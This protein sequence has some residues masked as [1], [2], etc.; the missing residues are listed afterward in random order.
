MVT[1]KKT[2]YP[3]DLSHWLVQGWRIEWELE[4]EK[5]KT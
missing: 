1:G 5:N 3:I 2:Y 4:I